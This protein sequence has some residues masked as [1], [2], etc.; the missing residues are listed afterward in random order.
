M[1]R[2]HVRR[3]KCSKRATKDDASGPTGQMQQQR[4]IDKL[5]G[6]ASEAVIRQI[7]G[8]CVRGS[9]QETEGDDLEH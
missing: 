9:V 4:T 3:V 5:R 8:G 2:A 7:G 1:G 6:G